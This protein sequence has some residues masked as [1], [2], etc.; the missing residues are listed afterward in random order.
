[1]RRGQRRC[2]RRKGRSGTGLPNAWRLRKGS[3]R[4]GMD[5]PPIPTQ[6]WPLSENF[7]LFAFVASRQFPATFCVLELMSLARRPVTPI[8]VLNQVRAPSHAFETTACFHSL[9]KLD[10][11][12]RPGSVVITVR[13]GHQAGIA[14]TQH[15]R[16]P[17][18][19]IFPAAASRGSVLA[20]CHVFRRVIAP[21]RLRQVAPDAH[22]NL[23][24]C[25]RHVVGATIDSRRTQRHLR[26]GSRDCQQPDG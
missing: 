25:S 4:P 10:L 19:F 3:F 23:A 18:C 6:R 7:L 15:Q 24:H 16:C 11:A 5:P 26:R 22:L 8:H 17:T 1:M 21:L 13:D 9:G 2:L 20:P 12:P 14:S